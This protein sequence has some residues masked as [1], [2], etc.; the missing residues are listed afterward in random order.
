MRDSQSATSLYRHFDSDGK[1]L[2]VGIAFRWDH[3][4]K[5][6][7]KYSEWYKN[8]SVLKIEHF[9]TREQ[10]IVAEVTAI[11]TEKPQFNIS[12]NGNKDALPEPELEK[13][14]KAEMANNTLIRR[15]VQFNPMYSI[16]GAAAVLD[17][18]EG[19][20]KRLIKEGKL[21][22]CILSERP[23]MDRFGNPTVQIKRVVTGWQLID[24]IESLEKKSHD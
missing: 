18:S 21:S 24:Y 3:R 1:L 17:M 14:T 13:L 22:S 8:I 11:K 10:A 4:T 5:Q 23:R 6:H 2:Y 7:A 20:V 16:R 19:D 15:I 12:H 9:A